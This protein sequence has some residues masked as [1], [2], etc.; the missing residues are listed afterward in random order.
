MRLQI[1][2]AQGSLR[3]LDHSFDGV[4]VCYAGFSVNSLCVGCIEV[5]E[6]VDAKALNVMVRIW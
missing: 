3:G 2:S 6:S 4:E 5:A 1:V